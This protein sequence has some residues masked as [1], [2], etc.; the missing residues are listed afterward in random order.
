[1][2]KD[3]HKNLPSLVAVLCSLE[4]NCPVSVFAIVTKRQL[5]GDGKDEFTF[6]VHNGT[7]FSKNAK[8][9]I[10]IEKNQKLSR[11]Q[12]QQQTISL[13]A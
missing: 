13:M 3:L 2:P 6:K 10:K 7:V 11:D 9:S 5:P 12:V 4:K 8:V 1:L